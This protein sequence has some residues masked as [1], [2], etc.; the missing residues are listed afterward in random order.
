MDLPHPHRLPA[1]LAAKP[2][3]PADRPVTITQ[4]GRSHPGEPGATVARR[5][6]HLFQPMP[7]SAWTLTLTRILPACSIGLA[8][9]S[10]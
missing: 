5:H 2:R 3:R 6:Q 10:R 1:P 4:P 8:G 9:S 7:S